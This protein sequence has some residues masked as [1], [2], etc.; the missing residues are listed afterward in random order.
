LLLRPV[1][2]HSNRLHQFH[3]IYWVQ[4][5]LLLFPD[6]PFLSLL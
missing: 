5:P 6:H 4:V 2:Y 1:I 3:Q